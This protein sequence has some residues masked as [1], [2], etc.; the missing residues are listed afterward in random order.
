MLGHYA[1][2]R[3]ATDPLIRVFTSGTTGTA[4]TV[5]VPVKA[6]A[7]FRI[8][9]EYG[10]DVRDDDVFWNA[11][12]PGWAYGMYYGI[13]GPLLTG[14][15]SLLLH[16]GFDVA[17]MWDVL[18]RFKVTNLA[19]PPRMYRALRSGEAR[20]PAEGVSLR[21][22]SSAGEPLPADLIS[23]A[24]ERLGAP[25]REGYG[26]TEL[27]MAIVNGW[28]PDIQGDV[29][30]G[31]MG[32]AMPGFN[33]AVLEDATDTT[34]SS[35]ADGRVAIDVPASPLMWFTGYAGDPSR[36]AK[37]FSSDGRWYFTG[38]IAAADD[39]GS[40]FFSSRED[41]VIIIAGHRTG[42]LEVE[43]ALL[44]HPDVAEAAVIGVPDEVQGQVLEA[45]IVL[46][47]GVS[48]SA[49]LIAALNEHVKDRHA[50][51]AHACSIHILDALPKT[52]SGK[53]QRF[54]LRERRRDELKSLTGPPVVGLGGR[55]LAF[56][57]GQRQRAEG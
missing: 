56:Q 47:E 35:G 57:R 22:C 50:A 49:A 25:I 17:L 3:R 37:R 40:F 15:R 42:P 1:G 36:T 30:P 26:Q 45:Y 11:A 43:S 53:V 20:L 5:P 19:A 18:E 54:I 38:D 55:D 33:A 28:H 16:A 9:M 48:A 13:L 8:Y 2:A 12:D 44:S 39:A 27:G 4:K 10:L 21:A 34:A 24:E 46:R 29:K 32:R 31:S 23:W 6:L 14:R 52:P 51:H 7:A 41:D